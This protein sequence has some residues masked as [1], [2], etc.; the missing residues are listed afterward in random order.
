VA[1]TPDHSSQADLP[2]PVQGSDRILY[3]EQSAQ[4]MDVL[5]EGMETNN[6]KGS[7]TLQGQVDPA[8]RHLPPPVDGSSLWLSKVSVVWWQRAMLLGGLMAIWIETGAA[9]WL[10]QQTLA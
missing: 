2:E 1:P 3:I 8:I 10:A 4:T 5:T 7:R 9:R 6:Q